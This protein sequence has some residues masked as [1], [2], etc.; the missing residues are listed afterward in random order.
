MNAPLI[1][2]PHESKRVTA[3]ESLVGGTIALAEKRPHHEVEA[4]LKRKAVEEFGIDNIYVDPRSEEL[5]RYSKEVIIANPGPAASA[6]FWVSALSQ[7]CRTRERYPGSGARKIPSSDFSGRRERRPRN[8]LPPCG[9]LVSSKS[10]CSSFNWR[11][12]PLSKEQSS[13]ASARDASRSPIQ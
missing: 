11:C 10:Q 2:V 9:D 1:G 13:T 6:L 4:D 12:S 8:F 3:V 5:L 7:S